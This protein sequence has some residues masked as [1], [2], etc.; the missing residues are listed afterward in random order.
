MNIDLNMFEKD[1]KTGLYIIEDQVVLGIILVYVIQKL[2]QCN[3]NLL[4]DT[5][6][7]KLGIYVR[8]WKTVFRNALNALKKLD[9]IAINQ[10]PGEGDVQEEHYSL[11]NVEFASP[12]HLAH[13]KDVLPKLLAD[14]TSAAIKV[15]FDSGEEAE[16]GETTKPKRGANIKESHVYSVRFESEEKFLAGRS[17]CP[18]MRDGLEKSPYQPNI[19][20]YIKQE[21]EE[22][23]KTK[24]K[25]A[26]DRA[27]AKI[28]RFF[29]RAT[30]GGILIHGGIT[31]GMFCSAIPRLYGLAPAT[32]RDNGGYPSIIVYPN[33][34]GIQLTTLPV[35]ASNGKSAAPQTYETIMP[36]EEILLRFWAPTKGF[37]DADIIVEYLE[38]IGLFP[39]RTLSP[40]R[41][42]ETGKMRMTHFVDHGLV[43]EI[44]EKRKKNRKK[45][46]IDAYLDWEFEKETGVTLQKV[47]GAPKT[48]K[49]R[50][51]VDGN[52]MLLFKTKGDQAQA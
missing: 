49:A 18:T 7:D 20:G 12:P 40:G 16:P 32:A 31:K 28:D 4:R 33:N 30:D 14:G 1:E 23:R 3:D 24:K 52:K 38:F 21:E 43:P 10:L 42:T 6:R 26:A 9:L 47:G 37:L 35:Q 22:P 45:L 51:R 48:K 41:G 19:D 36:G 44:F 11:K 13:F 27:D 34:H 25:K 5:L 8:K 29:E 39:K 46:P 15:A 17:I 50:M 2:G